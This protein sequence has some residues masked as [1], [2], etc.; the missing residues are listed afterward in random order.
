MKKNIIYI[1]LFSM[2]LSVFTVSCSEP[3]DEVKTGK[4]DRLFSPTNVEAIIQKKTN[5][6][7]KW[8]AVNNAASYI[9]ELYQNQDMTFEGTPKVYEGITDNTFTVEGLLGE[10]TYTAR[11]KAIGEEIDESK[12]SA[13]SFTT[14]AE[15]IF[16][17]VKDEDI[18]AHAVTL[19]WDAIDATVTR[20]V[21]S[22]ENQSDV[23]YQLQSS[24]IAN[25][26]AHVDGL[27]ESTSYTAKL[28]NVDKLR[29]TITFKT[30]I[31][32]HGKTPVYDGDDLISILNGASDGA[33]IVLV[34]GSFVI[35]DYLLNKSVIISGYDKTN[36]PTIYGRLQPEAGASS[37]EINNVIFRGDT[38]GAEE[39]VANFIEFQNGTNLSTLTIS[40]CEIRNYKNQI[41]YS[42]VTATLGTV[43]F[44]SSWVDNIPGSGGDGFDLRANTTLGTL[45]IQ[46]STFSNGLRTFLRCNTTSAT[47]NV[48]NCTFYKVCSYDNSNNNGLFLMDKVST[49]TGKLIVEK[50]V[51][52]EIGGGIYG[53]WSKKGKMKAQ[54][55]YSKNYFYAS[56]NLWDATNGLYTDPSACSATEV[57]PMFANPENGDFTIGA[58]DIK[59]SNAGDPRW[60]K[61]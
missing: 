13:V 23:E 17:S 28:Y 1:A 54:A 38:P 27:E 15:N 43:L 29:G 3:D 30:A 50:C 53:Y 44:E 33:N 57:N 25:K 10:T 47:V 56:P 26:Q 42:N 16:N 40:G 52:S 37:I 48:T 31:D 34:S 4:F 36:M 19:T 18:E 51:F 2:V 35:G 61:E 39:P 9:I 32:F 41:L 5:V 8:T 7:F 60:I 55:S 21:F 20:I 24:D 6:K 22:A 11:I 59:D 49:D 45:T 58:E 12:W 46:N 14:E